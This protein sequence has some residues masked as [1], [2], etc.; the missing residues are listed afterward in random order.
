MLCLKPK[1][2]MML[3]DPY[4]T[5]AEVVAILLFDLTKQQSSGSKVAKEAANAILPMLATRKFTIEKTTEEEGETLRVA[6]V[7]YSIPEVDDDFR[8]YCVDFYVENNV[9]NYTVYNRI[10]PVIS[11]YWTVSELQRITNVHIDKVCD[12]H[13]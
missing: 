11:D 9:L 6:F 5:Q 1:T 2:T 12:V 8:R 7:D 13:H 3:S 4:L 10:T